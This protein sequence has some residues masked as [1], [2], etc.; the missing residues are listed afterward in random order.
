M[1]DTITSV[2]SVDPPD[3]TVGERPIPTTLAR[4]VSRCLEKSPEVRFQSTRDL[5][6][7]L[8]SLSSGIRPT[9]E[10]D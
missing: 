9:N 4:I 3:L 2:L 1:P 7:A 6:F 10:A 5:A 8:E